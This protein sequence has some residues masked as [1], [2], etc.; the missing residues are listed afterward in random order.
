MRAL[1]GQRGGKG[2]LG[3][4]GQASCVLSSQLSSTGSA[5]TLITS[6]PSADLTS[7][8]QLARL[9]IPVRHTASSPSGALVFPL[10]AAKHAFICA[11]LAACMSATAQ[12]PSTV[13]TL[14]SHRHRQVA[15]D[16]PHKR[17]GKARHQS[18]TPSRPSPYSRQ[19]RLG[20]RKQRLR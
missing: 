20:F 7:S 12:R 10:D 16:A 3:R 6:A 11:A 15:D 4:C 5:L 13:M 8:A 17:A 2:R 19:P 1:K 18:S 14:H 9:I